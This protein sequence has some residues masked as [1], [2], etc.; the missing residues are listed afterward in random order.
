MTG[1]IAFESVLIIRAQHEGK[2][3]VGFWEIAANS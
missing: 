3:H 1:W 2:S